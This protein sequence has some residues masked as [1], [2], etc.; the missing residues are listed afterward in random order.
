[1][2]VAEATDVRGVGL[3][4][5][6]YVSAGSALLSVGVSGYSA[7][8]T[9]GTVESN[10]GVK[11]ESTRAN[12]GSIDFGYG[13]HGR[14]KFASNGNYS[15]YGDNPGNGANDWAGYFNG[16]TFNTTGIW[17][18]SD[19]DLKSGIEPLASATEL[20]LGLQPKTYQFN[21]DAYPSL[22]LPQGRQFGFLA[23]E[24]QEQ[25][26]EMVIETLHPAEV[27][28]MGQEIHP[29]VPFKAVNTTG[30]TPILVAAFQE[31]LQAAAEAT[32]VQQ[33]ELEELRASVAEQAAR[34]DALEAALS[35]CCNRP[36]GS[37]LVPQDELHKADPRTERLLRIDP[38]PF[39]DRTTIRYTLE[40]GGRT[41][42]LV[43]SSD[44][45]Q[46]QVLGEA[47][48]QAGDYQQEWHT[49]HLALGIYYVTFLLDG[50][51]LVKRAVK[52]H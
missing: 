39:T 48:Q 21:T 1:M 9:S 2:D 52:V 16:K 15:I 44:G 26:P 14:A 35:A 33:A 7:A 37:Q 4:G 24:L 6:A 29:A 42:L 43:N 20:I 49:S 27:D 40:R 3:Q 10:Y 18:P 25:F 31:Q 23:Q 41:M 51:P 11:G 13:V 8:R 47:V 46:L 19:G 30:I 32:A 17:S 38:N 50:E 22:G 28:T 45:K 36:D 5:F 12:P 34:M